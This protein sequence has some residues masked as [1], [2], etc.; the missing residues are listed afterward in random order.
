M[1]VRSAE[2]MARTDGRSLDP[3]ATTFVL[4]LMRGAPQKGYQWKCH[5]AACIASPNAMRPPVPK[6]KCF[7]ILRREPS[8]AQI[9]ANLLRSRPPVR[10]GV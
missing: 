8:P 2:R 7:N 3:M 6:R 9:R 1:A 5:D 4:T 10:K